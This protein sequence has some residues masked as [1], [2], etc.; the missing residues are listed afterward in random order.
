MTK[1]I[2]PGLN[3]KKIYM[4]SRG[5]SLGVK[6]IKSFKS[7]TLANHYLSVCFLNSEWIRKEM[8]HEVG[9]IS[10][11]IDRNQVKVKLRDIQY[12]FKNQ[13][14]TEYNITTIKD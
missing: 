5:E 10:K 9:G 6:H 4:G 1:P 3:W 13:I 14:R 11:R 2:M 8:Q 7:V 12:I